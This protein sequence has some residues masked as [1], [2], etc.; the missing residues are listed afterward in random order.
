MLI[1]DFSFSENAAACSEKVKA[2]LKNCRILSYEN[3]GSSLQIIFDSCFRGWGEIISAARELA[4][5]EWFA[6]CVSRWELCADEDGECFTEDLL[7]YCRKNGKGAFAFKK[8]PVQAP[9]NKGCR[10]TQ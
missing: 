2:I 3:N 10:K 4:K 5:L 6:D 7:L 1:M 9:Q 8:F